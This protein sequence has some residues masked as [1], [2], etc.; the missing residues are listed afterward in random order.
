MLQIIL[1]MVRGNLFFVCVD[2]EFEVY[3]F[4]NK[5]KIRKG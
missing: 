1:A 5:L 3:M 4:Y 2:I